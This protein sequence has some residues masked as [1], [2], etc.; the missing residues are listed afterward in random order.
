MSRGFGPPLA[1][2]LLAHGGAVT[3][4]AALGAAWLVGS[5]AAPSSPPALYVDLVHPIVA[6]SDRHETRDAA[7][8]LEGATASPRLPTSGP[9]PAVR[10]T[11]PAGPPADVTDT[12]LAES[13]EPT[14]PGPEVP[15]HPVM[16][17]TPAAR[18]VGA[19]P[20]PTVVPELHTSAR[21]SSSPPPRDFAA[22]LSSG[23][24]DGRP[25]APPGVDIARPSRNPGAAAS[26]LLVTA[27]PGPDPGDAAR[28]VGAGGANGATSISGANAAN[29][30]DTA[31]EGTTL[32]RLSPG[33][34][35]S[36][37]A[38]ESSVPPEYEAYV[39]ALRQRIQERLVYPWTAVRR[40]QQGVVELELR[41]DADGRLIAVEVVMG[42]SADTLRTAAVTAVRGSA[43]FPFPAGP[44]GR[45]LVIRLP[46]EFRLR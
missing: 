27:E 43:P 42:A 5:P 31:S 7:P 1:L 24:V 12:P 37:S 23:F 30:A 46:V 4:V 28:A 39:R 8:R 11:L 9:R 22:S 36:G 3:A 18:D 34:K 10:A 2:S 17:A 41:V 25:S 32:A 15:R 40:A 6:T 21:V 13:A 38:P 35:G 14:R 45:P 16:P 29:A 26:G 20:P 19:P 33:E 44:T